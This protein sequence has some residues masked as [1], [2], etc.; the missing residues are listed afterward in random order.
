M[1][2]PS[3]T[4]SAPAR[5]FAPMLRSLPNTNAL[6][7]TLRRRAFAPVDV[8]ILVY[9]R[10][11]F[12]ALMLWEVWRY[13]HLGRIERYWIGPKFHFTYYGFDWVHPWPG[14]GMYTHFL[15]MGIL[16]VCIMAGYW[17]RASAT[18]FW[19]AFTYMF[20]LDQALYLNHFYLIC[21]VSFLMIFI[22][23][24]RSFSID[25][26][27]RPEVRSAVAPAWSLWLLRAQI[28]VVYVFGGIAKL[29]ADWLAGQPLKLW[30]ADRTDFP[31]IGVYFTQAWAAYF[32][33]YGGLLLD[34]LVVPL[35]LWRKTRWFAFIVAVLFHVTNDRL[36]AI[37]VF[38]WFMIAATALFFPAEWPR[39]IAAR[40]MA[41]RL[42]PATDTESALETHSPVS[43]DVSEPVSNRFSLSAAGFNRTALSQRH[44]TLILALLGLYLAYQLLFPLR[45]F[46]YPG[47][48]SWSEEGHRFSWH[49]KLRDKEGAA[50]FHVTDPATGESRLV[51]PEEYLATW[52][53][54]DMM[55]HPDMILQFSQ[56]L[57]RTLAT[58]HGRPLEVRAWV[59]VS[60][61][62]RSPQLLV[63]PHVDLAAQ[64]RTWRPSPWILPF[65][66]SDAPAPAPD[67]LFQ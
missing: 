15:V 45:H 34:L 61:N 29:N 59:P 65:V 22:P 58:Q 30:L 27:R 25:A 4:W 33:S 17:Y 64:P 52:Q 36:F 46:L 18:L 60:L 13:L 12:G 43:R 63:D 23:A 56:F 54:G 66:E 62:G 2:L 26:W 51:T 9:F 1:Q 49:M 16:A 47:N 50:V 40:L 14:D 10:L 7:L 11:A 32:F 57:A 6:L 31:L 19:L 39:R 5:L 35:L 21:L 41:V 53:I 3:T 67:W 44:Q 55:V 8:A 38:P 28:A 20:L 48:V 42:K 37:G 24:H